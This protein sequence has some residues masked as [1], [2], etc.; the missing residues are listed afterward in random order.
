MLRRF[1]HAWNSKFEYPKAV[2]SSLIIL[3]FRLSSFFSPQYASILSAILCDYIWLIPTQ[4]L[5]GYIQLNHHHHHHYLHHHSICRASNHITSRGSLFCF[6][7]FIC[8]YM[9]PRRLSPSVPRQPTMKTFISDNLQASSVISEE[10]Y[11]C[12]R[13][14]LN[15]PH[16]LRWIRAYEAE[17]STK[18]AYG[19]PL[20]Y[21]F[22]DWTSHDIYW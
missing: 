9:L 4:H 8:S 6:S 11:P 15:C 14:N 5:S 3:I 22:R 7:S 10:L 21:N 1:Y 16:I 20:H 12:R 17:T 18:I 13:Q 2:S 19:S